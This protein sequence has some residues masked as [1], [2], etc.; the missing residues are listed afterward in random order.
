MFTFRRPTDAALRR[1]VE[2][3]HGLPFTY[4]EVG[5]TADDSTTSIPSGYNV[6]RTRRKLGAGDDDFQA[7]KQ[8]L[9]NWRHF[10]LGWLGV[11]QTSIPIEAGAVAVVVARALGLWSA[12]TARIVYVV[13]EPR[14]FGFAYGTLPGHAEQGEE[15]F[16]VEQR[17]DGSVW[18]DVV[19]FSHP[20]HLLAR[21]AY[22]LVR[23]LQKSF[24]PATADALA[25]A[26][27]EQPNTNRSP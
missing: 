21:L 15:R 20:R 11:W 26:M 19:A 27:Q 4:V 18:Y 8:A 13:D 25:R 22:P 6:D 10:E 1:F 24:G 2:S 12:H 7:A 23:R 3:Q 14:R 5:A 17:D 16:L 9:R